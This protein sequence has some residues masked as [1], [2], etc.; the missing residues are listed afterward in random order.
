MNGTHA[1]SDDELPPLA[2]ADTKPLDAPPADETDEQKRARAEATKERG[3][4]AFKAKRYGEA[5]DL[6]ST[7]VGPSPAR[8]RMS[9][10][11]ADARQI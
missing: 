3:N 10:L 9:R 5:L 6:Y 7:A 1:D 11:G 2:D 4:V 8:R